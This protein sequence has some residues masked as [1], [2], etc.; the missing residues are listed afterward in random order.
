MTRRRLRGWAC[1][2][3]SA[4]WLR[5]VLP[6]HHRRVNSR[7]TDSTEPPTWVDELGQA[8]A[9]PDERWT[10]TEV[11]DMVTAAADMDAWLHDPRP[12]KGKHEQGWTSAVADLHEAAAL[13][14]PKLDAA[15]GAELTNALAATT[16]L[17]GSDPA[18]ALPAA[19]TALAALCARWADPAV[20]EEAWCDIADACRDPQTPYETIAA[21]RDV[22]WQL[23]RADR[24]TRELSRLLAGV[25]EDNAL[26]VCMARVHLGDIPSPGPG[27]WPRPDELAGLAEP[28]RIG[29][30]RRVLATPATPANH[31]VW[32]AFDR[33]SLGGGVS[34]TVGPITFYDGT[35]VRETLENDGP[36]QSQLPVELTNLDS[37]LR[38]PDLPKGDRIVLARVDLGTGVFA[39]APRV[40]AE[41]AQAVVTIASVQAGD[42][43][44]RPLNG[45]IHVTDGR[46]TGWWSF[47]TPYDRAAVAP[48]FDRTADELGKLAATLGSRL[49]VTDPALNEA[50]DALGW[51]QDA[52]DQ[53]PLAA[54]VLDVLVLERVAAR[55]PNGGTWHRY[56]D[57][58]LTA[59]W[60]HSRIIN[61]LRSAVFAAVSGSHS[62]FYEVIPPSKHAQLAAL[63]TKIFPPIPGGRRAFHADRAV[64][65]LPTL[66]T[67]WPVHD[68]VGRQVHTL[69]AHLSS[70]AD[71]EVW[72]QALQDRWPR[73]RERLQ[74]IRNAL[75]HGGP[76]TSATAETV[77]RLAHQLAGG[78]LSFTLEG[79][80][81]G[82]GSTQAHKD[83]RVR[84][85]AWRNGVSG[86]AS[87]H[88][89]LFPS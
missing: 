88:D 87:V 65:A 30:C 80:L 66:A 38:L 83:V 8:M 40:A 10:D 20:V 85:T 6:G 64:D 74:R 69:A 77:H 56:L 78:A 9:R 57:S 13:I 31:V 32:V 12:Y 81:D 47:T 36:G 51:W 34:Q 33:A 37:P 17:P 42:R 58:H 41:Q 53:P 60:I 14:G 22:F 73:A 50:V 71:L 72:C 23:V 55:V 45:N 68:R 52:A 4:G 82:R 29:L 70:P 86:A 89:A 54:I 27:A 7:T 43:Y 2:L 19:K 26:V 49:P 76:L 35:W 63:E 28:D 46:V 25:L 15:L 21:R 48:D 79:L 5:A 18:P 59:G 39:D 16:G 75:A 62:G 44:W 1:K 67:I 3:L 24:N 84:M 11:L 61:T